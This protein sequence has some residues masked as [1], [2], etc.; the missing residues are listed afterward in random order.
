MVTSDAPLTFA[1]EDGTQLYG[2]WYE[3]NSPLGTAVVL[4]GYSEH[5]GR[6]REVAQQL[7]LMGLSVLAYDMRG[8]G[9]SEGARGYIQGFHQYLQDLYAALAVAKSRSPEPIFLVAHS[10]GALVALRMLCDPRAEDPRITAAVFSSPFL[11]LKLPVSRFKRAVARLASIAL[12]SLTLPRELQVELLTQDPQKQQERK[13]DPLCHEVV[14][15][16]WFTSAQRAQAYVQHMSHA[17]RIPT[18]WFIAEND[19]IADPATTKDTIRHMRSEPQVHVLSRMEHE[20]FNELGRSVV[21]QALRR[22][23]AEQLAK[24]TKPSYTPTP[25]VM[26]E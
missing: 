4:H 15:A 14:S 26:Q 2:E 8:H 12:P 25:N 16:R 3:T 10:N 17:I 21:F 9:R 5:C 18:L 7:R 1:S 22:F 11:E 23:I 20:V 19:R 6:Y 24:R 13:L